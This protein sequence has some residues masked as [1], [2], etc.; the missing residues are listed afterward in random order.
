M[1]SIII[2][3]KAVLND[4]LNLLSSKK[5]TMKTKIIFTLFFIVL[6][7]GSVMAE[8]SDQV[9]K[10]NLQENYWKAVKLFE[11]EDYSKSLL[12][13]QNLLDQ[14]SENYEL[15]Y[16]VGMCYHKLDKSKLANVYFKI[17]A[18]D[19]VC[20]IK[21]RVLAQNNRDMYLYDI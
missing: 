16:Y 12:Y 10:K 13:F 18:D 2:K 17:A 14:N 6:F 15:N 7:K 11:A 4:F 8:A 19:S 1:T 21:I 20:L 9:I 5:T 3:I